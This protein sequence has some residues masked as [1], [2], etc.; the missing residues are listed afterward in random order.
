MVEGVKDTIPVR[1]GEELNIPV[2]EAFIKEY[3]E[4]IPD[5]PLMVEQFRAGHSNL[6]YQLSI[7]DWEAVLRRP[8]HGPVAPKAHDMNREYKILKE[9]NPLFPSAPKPYLFS[10]NKEIVGS[11][12]F[13]MERK[14]GIVIDTE[15]PSSIEATP[16]LCRRISE[17]MVEQLVELHRIDYMNTELTK[18]SHPDGFM[19]RQVHGWLSRCERAKTDE[20]EGFD[21][22][23]KWLIDSIPVSG[24]PTVIH[25]D[26][27]LNNAMFS[28]DLTEMVG[29]F[30]WEMTTIGDPLADLGAAMS[31]WTQDDD[32]IMLKKGL[33]KAPITVNKG[34]FTR[35]EF[36]EMYAKKSGRDVSNIDF[37]VTFA[38][39]KL[40]VI[41]QQIYFRYKNGQTSDNRFAH[42]NHFVNSLIQHAC[43]NIFK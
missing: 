33:G 40:A 4:G 13:I 23:K 16:D 11:T 27:K 29:L 30:D 42:F 5:K 19:E 3:L 41:C 10:E 20:I 9:L 22:L 35:N 31:Y 7:G 39:F 1:K 21:F 26:Y 12:F 25:Y 14:K 6:T 38:Y 8:P 43:N 28:K 24:T 17:I 15:F 2:L 37:Y 36:I 18:L 32:P 34:F